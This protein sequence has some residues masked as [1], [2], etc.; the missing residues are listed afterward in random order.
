MSRFS[1]TRAQRAERKID[2]EGRVDVPV[3]YAAVLQEVGD[4]TIAVRGQPFVRA[5]L[6]I[7]RNP[8]AVEA[9]GPLLEPRYTS[10]HGAVELTT[11]G[12]RAR[13]D[14]GVGWLG[15]GG[16]EP[17]DRAEAIAGRLGADDVEDLDWAALLQQPDQG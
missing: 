5:H 13:V 9:L 8:S 15:S 3:Q 17:S 16:L 14:Q 4:R 12:N 2:I 10:L 7:D 6:F 1:H 11:Q